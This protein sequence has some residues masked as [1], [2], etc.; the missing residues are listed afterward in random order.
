MTLAF[1]GLVTVLGIVLLVLATFRQRDRRALLSL[2][3][4]SLFAAWAPTA[5]FF[6]LLYAAGARPAGG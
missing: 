2:G 6:V 4:T 3:L 5:V 1:G